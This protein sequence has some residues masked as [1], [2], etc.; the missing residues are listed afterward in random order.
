MRH[1]RTIGRHST[2]RELVAVAAAVLVLIGLLHVGMQEVLHR[3][4]ASATQAALE[5][6]RLKAEVV[7]RWAREYLSGLTREL[8]L[9][10]ERARQV[11][12]GAAQYAYFENRLRVLT[13]SGELG[14]I[15][16]RFVAAD[17]RS[18]WDAGGSTIVID[19]AVR[20]WV[21]EAAT[22][23]GQAVFGAPR[24]G[25]GPDGWSIPVSMPIEAVDG[26]PLGTALVLLDALRAGRDLE[27]LDLGRDEIASLW[28]RDGLLLAGSFNLVDGL[29]HGVKVE[30][31]RA[32]TGPEERR[33][34]S[35]YN[36]VDR[37]VAARDVAGF[38]LFVSF[39]ALAGAELAAFDSERAVL[40]A[41]ELGGVALIVAAGVLAHLLRSRGRSRIERIVADHA[42]TAA[43]AREAELARVLD[44]VD[45]GI[46][47]IRIEPGPVFIRYFVSAGVGRLVD[48]R[49]S[50]VAAA[51]GLLTWAEPPVT[52]EDMTAIRD[53]LQATGRY[54]FERHIRCGDGRLRW[55][56]FQMR[57]VARDGGTLDTIGL[58]TDIDVERSAVAGA[59]ASARLA[60]LGEISVGFAH[61]INQPLATISLLAG[62]AEMMMTGGG[63]P[64]AD[65]IV[66]IQ[67]RIVAMT[68]RT[69]DLADHLRSMARREPVTMEAV[70]VAAAI[71]GALE[72]T[73]AVARGAGVTVEKRLAAGLPPVS[74]K[75]VLLEQV[76]INLVL[77]ARDAMREVPAGGRRLVIEADMAGDAVCVRVR[78]SGPGIPADVLPRLFEPFFTTKPAGQGTGVGLSICS[79]IMHGCGG[80]I[81]ARNLPEGGAEFVLLLRVAR[82]DVAAA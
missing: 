75:R 35:P 12:L 60:T 24:R 53:A 41:A 77:N 4:Q 69:R 67:Q 5:R 62:A 55:L 2:R 64:P 63:Q 46:Y 76:L 9:L 50:E 18:A 39:S 47:R 11:A 80:E 21:A 42:L 7:E 3:A 57:V 16:A 51:N 48:R 27:Q 10:R 65:E 72:L 68:E 81:S 19:D 14:I 34:P 8:D 54:V 25:P 38:P 29:A 37:F 66:E 73:D 61:E 52:R 40:A 28:R 23:G 22:G 70:S 32:G 30:R 1:P 33:M 15:E 31:W 49:L 82:G 44:E 26:T 43:Q 58:V 74:A 17:G 78:D 59:A 56:R 45:A 6:A 79:G 20:A 13:R 71:D 36:G